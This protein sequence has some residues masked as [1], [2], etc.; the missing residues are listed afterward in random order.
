MRVGLLVY[1]SLEALSG[2]YLYDRKL[3]EH[4]RAAGDEVEIVSVPW[5]NYLRHLADNVSARLGQRLLN[6]RWDVLLQ[7]ELNHP[8][9]FWLNRWLKPRV[10]YPLIS[11]VHH[12]RCSELRPAWQNA[13]Y[14]LVERAYLR[15]VNGFVF[16]SETT[17][18]VVEGVSGL[19][20]DPHPRPF[21]LKG[22]RVTPAII[23]H[24]AADHVQPALTLPQI[25]ARAA[26]PGPLRALFVGNII[27]RKGLHTLLVA[28]A[29]VRGE[30][31]L[32]AVG[33][34]EVDLN[35][36]ARIRA[37]VEA[38]HGVS[39]LGRLTDAE[40]RAQLETHHVLAVPS[41][42]EGFGIVYLEAMAY[43]L[44]V[45]ATTAGA[46]REIV[47]DG[48]DGFLV[49]PEDPNALAAALQALLDDRDRLRAMSL[50][51]RARYERHPT[52][53]QSLARVREFLRGVAV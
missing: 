18:E 50:A 46:A 39:L 13:L 41:S 52:W 8:S 42:Y 45:I 48:V 7:D 9:L 2:G 3:V 32:S 11:L 23:A 24:P 29:Q 37:E 5:R 33:R 53:A 19:A 47:T 17:R 14:R 49:P 30:W 31:Q 26:T 12:L 6:G 16:N 34:L 44:P 51:A 21:S 22:R 4:L 43:G 1:G 20:F 10:R 28:V 27:P 15:S 25:E 38:H 36:V 40:L 35:Y